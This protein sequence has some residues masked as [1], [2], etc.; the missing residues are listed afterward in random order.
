[1]DITK[2]IHA[3]PFIGNVST[4]LM[5][6]LVDL[7]STKTL[8]VGEVLAKQFEVGQYIYFLIEGEIAISVPLQ[9]TGKSYNVG[10]INKPL[11]PVGWSAFRHPSRYATT[12]TATKSSTLILWPIVE[13]QKIL[14]TDLVLANRF[15]QFVYEESLPILTDIQNQTRPF[16]SNESLAFEETRPLVTTEKPTQI[17]KD[18]VNLLNYAPFCETFTQAEIHTLAKQSTTLLAHQ[19]DIISQQDQPSDGLY[20]LIKGKVVVSYQT[21]TGDIITTRSI[22]RPGTILAWTTKNASMKNRTSII[23][24]RDSSILYIAQKDLLAIFEE[25]PKFSV[26]Y[27]YRLIWLIGTHLLSARMRYLS[28]I[29]NDEVLAVSNVIEQNAALLP[30][31]SPLYKVSELLKSAITTD[32]AFGVLYKCLH[33]GC[34]LER[35]IAGMCLDILK[36]LQ[37]ENAFYRHLQN[38]YDTINNLPKETPALDARRLG[39]ELFKQAFQQVPYVIKGLENLPKKAGSLFIYNHLL[40]SPTNRLP[41]GFRFSM[42]AQFISAMVIDNEYGVSGQRVVRRSKESE[43]WRDDFYSRFGNV[44]ISSWDSLTKDTPE[45]DSFIQQSQTTLRNNFPLMISPEG[46]SFSTSQSPGP[47]LPHAFE[48]AASMGADEPWIVPVAVAN[49]DKRADHNLYTVIV[50]PAFKLSSRVNPA[51]K[52]ALAQFLI[53][54]QAEYKGY[55]DEAVNLSR[56]IHQYPILSGQ[57]GYRSNVMGLNQIDVEFESDVR[58]LEFHLAYQEYKERPVAFFG[59]STMR[60]WHDFAQHFRDKDGINLGF[61]GATLE[62]CVYYF[63]RIIL[64]HKPRSLVIYAGDNDIGNQCDSNRVIELYIQLLEKIDRHLTGIPVTLISIKCSPA[65]KAMR[66]TIEKTNQQLKRLA[67]TRPNTR[68]LDLFT[69]LIDKNGEMKENLFENDKLHI[70]HKAYDLW[71]EKLLE[72][73]SFVFQK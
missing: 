24:S 28:Q 36:D 14:E 11:S 57:N 2:Q 68:Y 66:G 34:V 1:M 39:T 13:L 45:Y 46:Q 37:R 56:E 19:G 5:T 25:N 3:F 33:F 53:D 43:F 9:D 30:V 10:L 27:L 50:K 12:F 20:L 73:E 70:N 47:L 63:E 59:S 54:Y 4:E 35:T 48:I 52:E 58:E 18:A 23:S 60:L 40:G 8:T 29:A 41:N 71:T 26:K 55:V 62:A 67:K 44:F 16:F 38:V 32:E 65:R 6:S 21:E 17:I 64:P 7:A 61:G 42:D 31:S 15:L 51:D 22:S 69:L 49:F 72:I